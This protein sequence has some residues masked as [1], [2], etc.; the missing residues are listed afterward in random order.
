MGEKRKLLRLISIHL[1]SIHHITNRLVQSQRWN[2]NELIALI[3]K[4]LHRKGFFI[5]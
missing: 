2:N 5:P 3:I 1:V 4:A